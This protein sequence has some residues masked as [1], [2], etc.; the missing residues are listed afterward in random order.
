LSRR[1]RAR[2]ATAAPRRTSAVR[3]PSPG[4]R[5]AR[6]GVCHCGTQPEHREG[7]ALPNSL[8]YPRFVRGELRADPRARA[9]F[10]SVNAKVTTTTSSPGGRA[11]RAA[12]RGGSFDTAQDFWCCEVLAPPS[13]FGSHRAGSSRRTKPLHWQGGRAL[14][15]RRSLV[16][17]DGVFGR[18][19]GAA[20]R[21]HL[22]PFPNSGGPGQ[23][24]R[25][26]E[27]RL[28]RLPHGG[29]ARA[30]AQGARAVGRPARGHPERGGWLGRARPQPGPRARG[31][32]GR[33]ARAL[34]QRR[35]G[36]GGHQRHDRVLTTSA[37]SFPFPSSLSLIKM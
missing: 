13:E 33:G 20:G 27:P 18:C 28:R 6:R 14:W 3:R 1:P 10:A 16:A 17:A 30:R 5:A 32:G 26:N 37:L 7:A 4:P 36:A 9:S 21:G 25:A 23:A 15:A 24:R 2:P 29:R 34:H 11:L 19:C 8:C 22:Q 31:R 35:R 12:R